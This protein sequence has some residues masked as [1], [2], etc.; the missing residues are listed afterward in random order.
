MLNAWIYIKHLKFNIKHSSSSL[1]RRSPTI[2]PLAIPVEHGAWGFLLEPIALGLLVAPSAPG[3]LIGL[4]GI[5]V[6]LARH[7]LKLAMRDWL[8]KRYPRTAVCELLAATYGLAALIT[9]GAAF[10][11]ALIPLIFAIPFG[12]VQFIYD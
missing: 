5:A 4:G 6:Y 8:H 9:L 1:L 2:R 3:V 10:G 12:L 7:P 11:S